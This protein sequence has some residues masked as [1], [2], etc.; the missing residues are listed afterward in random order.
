MTLQRVKFLSGSDIPQVHR[1]MST[2]PGEELA[3][4]RERHVKRVTVRHPENG[5]FLLHLG[6]G[7]RLVF[8]V[9]SA[10]GGGSQAEGQA[11][12]Q[13]KARSIAHGNQP[14]LE[15]I[16]ASRQLCTNIER[17]QW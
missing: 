9:F 6:W 1:F 17:A 2:R 13:R 10:D 5:A 11:D 3:V 4:R 16:G 8:G 12:Y 15:N 7:H 14:L